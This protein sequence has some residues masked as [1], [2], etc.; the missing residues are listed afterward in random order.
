MATPLSVIHGPPLADEEG[1]GALTLPGWLR[2]VC[3]AGGTNEALVFHEGGVR[4]AWTYADL[5]EQAQKVA[6]ALLACG[7]GKGTRV[8]VLM[9]NRP[10]FLA[11]VWG[12]ALAGGVATTLNTFSTQAELAHLLKVSGVSVLLME[13]QVLKKDFAAMLGG[14]EPAVAE[15]RGAAIHAPGLPF[16]RHV[17][18]VGAA[19]QESDGIEDWAT[20]LA[21]GEAIS[22]A[23][24]EAS[25][26]TVTPA[27][28]GVLFFS[29]GS[30]AMPKGILSSHRAV[31]LQL[32]RWR[33]FYQTKA[34]ARTWSANGFFFSGNFG[35]AIGG[36]LSAGGTLV[37]QA[38]FQ[39][40]EALDLM[41]RER[42]SMAIAWPHQWAQLA[43]ASNFAEVDL[44]A[45]KYI[46]ARHAFGQ[47]PTITAD[48]DE[49][50]AAYGNTETFT[51]SAIYPS[52]TPEAEK[53]GSSGVPQPGMTFKIVDPLTGKAVPVGERGEIAV[54][55]PTLMMG[56]LG[57]PLDETLDDE[58]FFCTGDGGRVDAAGRLFWEGRLNDI[59]K[60]GGAN[61]SPLEIDAVIRQC[62]GVRLNQT[63][64]V[65]H[66]L[67]GE[68]VVTAVVAQDGAALE[69]EDVRAFAKR[70]LASYK[71]PRRVLFFA[72]EDLKTTG[73]AKIKTAD[74]REMAARRL[75]GEL[76]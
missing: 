5:L 46:S 37:L 54:K 41:A 20:F 12:T 64:G 38:T 67:L 27:D 22:P 13:R 53:A 16:L 74:L 9:T 34:D 76:A 69:E 2:E 23:L 3:E 72:E 10:E 59:I 17:A 47:H 24:V 1:L 52:G 58:G 29:S 75:E 39:A 18:A 45:M 33:R 4:V 31:A 51:I 60:T 42:V 36:T 63:V 50:M 44:S 43:A 26:A 15:A 61:V 57:I 21:R 32:W 25:A 73:S 70:T 28:P 62:P 35:M 14:I 11:A 7:T 65:P 8:G 71:V 55:G 56:Y 66:D 49:P 68:I 19:P 48:W 40:E 30:T 6:R